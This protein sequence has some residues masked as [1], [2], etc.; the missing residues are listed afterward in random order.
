MALGT[1]AAIGLG[2]AAIGGIANT[3]ANLT[4]QERARV[5]QD[6]AFQ[7]WMQINIPDPAQQQ[8]ALQQFVDQGDFTPQMEKAIKQAPSDF[9]KITTNA[10]YQGAQN[11][12]LSELQNIGNQGGLRLQDKV[13]LQESMLDQ[14]TKDR[15]NREGITADME[16]RGL[17]GSGFE[18]ASQLAAQQSGADRNAQSSLSVAAQAQQRALDALMKSGELG[19][20]Y[21]GQDFNEQSQKAQAADAINRFNTQSLQNVQQRNIGAQNAAS[22]QNLADKQRISDMNTNL[23]NDQQRYNKGLAQQ[24]FDNQMK[25]TGAKTGLYNQ[26]AQGQLQQGQS[27]GNLFTNIG[28]GVSGAANS[29]AQKD[30]WDDYLKKQQSTAGEV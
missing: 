11:K 17:G 10:T 13:A 26:Q 19:T 24:Q 20:Q 15:A 8:L 30:Y 2:A 5:A 16:R 29:Q 7:E 14:Q 18:F 21:R 1:A 9:Q 3:V 6:K 23:S 12:A 25:L 4:A 22:Q 28:S 27:L